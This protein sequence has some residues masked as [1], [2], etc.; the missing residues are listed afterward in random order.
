MGFVGA[1]GVVRAA[2]LPWAVAEDF[3]AECGEGG[4]VFDEFGA[5]VDVVVDA[6]VF[7]VGVEPGL[8][9]FGP[10]FG[11]VAAG[12]GVFP[13]AGGEGGG[14]C[15]LEALVEGGVDAVECDEV[16]GVCELVDEDG[17][18]VVGVAF[19]VEDVFFG[20]GDGGAV[21]G[22]AE[23]A[24]AAVPVVG[25]GEVGV[26]GDVGGA[27]GGGHD[28]EADFV[29]GEGFEEVGAV[30]DHALDDE[31]GF[32]ECGIVDFGGGDDGEGADEEV[33]LIEGCE[34]EVLAKGIAD[35]F[36]RIC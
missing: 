12:V 16:D 2:V 13:F 29:L 23:A 8:D 30:A 1:C 10:V 11:V 26:F 32:G 31:C 14:V 22:G 3:L 28:G 4:V 9:G 21:A 36:R 27:L 18:G 34:V 24:G 33:F 25:G 5:G 7:A 19:E 17:F 15:G 6:V 20:A 35:G